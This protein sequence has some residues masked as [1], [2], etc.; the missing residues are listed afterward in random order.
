[1]PQAEQYCNIAFSRAMTMNL[2]NNLS[3]DVSKL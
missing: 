3:D 1:M 2:D